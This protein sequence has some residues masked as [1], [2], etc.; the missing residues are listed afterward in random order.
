MKTMTLFYVLIV[1]LLLSLFSFSTLAQDEEMVEPAADD[2][3]APA[4]DPAAGPAAPAEPT[5]MQTDVAAAPAAPGGKNLAENPGQAYHSVGLR[6][7]WIFVPK[8]FITM[9]NVD[10]NAQNEKHP[11]ISNLGFGAEYTYRKDNFDIT[12]AFWYA[13][14]DW[15][16]P[17]YF[18]NGD[19][20]PQSWTEVTSG[21]SAL[22]M[23]AD[24]IWSAPIRD[25]VAITY[26]VGLGM[27]ITVGD[28]IT[29]TEAYFDGDELAPCVDVGNPNGEY[30]EV[31]GEYGKEYDKLPVVPWINLLVGA[32]FKPHEHMAIYVDTGFGIGFQMGVRGGY[33]F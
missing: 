4:G 15:E 10:I 1:G 17:I 9:F 8:W 31:G 18:K 32:R 11:L 22:L 27:G 13:Q 29:E 12:A 19:E 23:T 5:P 2:W 7:R 16:D 33:I 3:G 28:K 21:L 24:F 26:G 14:L 30:C 20:P 25:W 6:F